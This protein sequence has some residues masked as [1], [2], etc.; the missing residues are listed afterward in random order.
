M[1]YMPRAILSLIVAVL[2]LSGCGG[3]SEDTSADAAKLLT[4]AAARMERVQ[5]FHYLLEHENGTTAIVSGVQMSR[6]EGDVDGPERMRAT[7]LGRVG[8]INLET[9]IVIL[10]ADSWF[11]NPLTRR[12]ERQTISIDQVFDPQDG[13]VAL[14]RRAQA[15]R[16]AGTDR[17]GDVEVRRVE[18]TLDSADLTLLP[19]EPVPGKKV[20]VAAWIGR[21]D[22][23]VHR[24]EL[25][26]AAA[27]SEPADI[28][29]RITLTRFDE[30]VT[31]DP[32]R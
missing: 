10:G 3:G 11:Q 22:P 15:P 14:M 21:S 23:L 16:V 8:T 13:V 25:R 30:A 5:R 26:G 28:L 4:D 19:G 17:I 18:A 6:A 7:I 29:R 20:N 32:P 24:I 9:G 1:H 2:L 31:I 27:E 12:W